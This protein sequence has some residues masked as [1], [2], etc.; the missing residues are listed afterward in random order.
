MKIK[1]INRYLENLINALG[2]ENEANRE[3]LD[4]FYSYLETNDK[5]YL[6]A[7]RNPEVDSRSLQLQYILPY[8]RTGRT[9]SPSSPS[10][11]C[12]TICS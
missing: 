11:E 1:N 9:Q 2:E 4:N 3:M 8:S 10:R 6:K 7:A 5:F 12:R